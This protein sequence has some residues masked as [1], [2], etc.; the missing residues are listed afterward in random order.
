MVLTG[1]ANG[2]ILQSL[3]PP[4]AITTEEVINCSVVDSRDTGWVTQQQSGNVWNSVNAKESISEVSPPWIDKVK[5]LKNEN[6][7]E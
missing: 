4:S 1:K 2:K 7:D 3:S 6:R 5:E